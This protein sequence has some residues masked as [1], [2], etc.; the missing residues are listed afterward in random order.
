[1]PARSPT[2]ALGSACPAREHSWGQTHRRAAIAHEDGRH[3]RCTPTVCRV[4]H[5]NL[6]AL[7]LNV[8]AAAAPRAAAILSWLRSRNEDVFVLTET[9]AGNGTRLL[10]D[11]LEVMGYRTFFATDPR[12]RGVAVASRI[13]VHR[14][15][16]AQMSLTLPWRASA[17]VLDTQ[18]RVA[19]IGV[20]VP[21]RDRSPLKVARK[22][23]FLASLLDSIRGLS[24]SLRGR[25][26]VVGDYNVVARRHAPRIPGFFPYE[27]AFHEQLE[28]LGLKGAHELGTT[29][30]HQ[31]HSWIGRTGNGY[32]YDYVHVGKALQ[33]SVERCSYL[34]GPR[35]RRLTDHAAVTV[36]LR[37]T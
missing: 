13:P 18:P 27:Y 10:L 5:T 6:R 31:P 3:R 14:V 16:D 32:L 37:L 28:N 7:S 35:E 26:L 21:S 33:S 20:Y 4:S 22:E 25:L 12:D 19:M 17:I 15:L 29:A 30:A 34:H 23:A 9:S 8:G 2:T 1:M 11:G 24:A 36:R